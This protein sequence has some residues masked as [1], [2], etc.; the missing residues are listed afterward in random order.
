M[1][2]FSIIFTFIGYLCLAADPLIVNFDDFS[3]EN[4]E[5]NSPLWNLQGHMIQMRGFWYSLSPDEGLLAS[6]PHLKSCCLKAP[7]KIDQQLLVKGKIASFST[8]RAITLEGVFKIEP[9]Y[10]SEG[11]LIQLFVLEQPVLV[12][13]SNG[14]L[15][16]LILGVF[17]VVFCFWCFCFKSK[18]LPDNKYRRE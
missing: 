6:Q 9:R 11:Q 1:T 10:N 7:A 14:L 2:K 3:L 12:S 15:I 5:R 16:W 17:F 13:E 8:K 18:I 4:S